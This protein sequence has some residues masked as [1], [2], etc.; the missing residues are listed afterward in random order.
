MIS[1]HGALTVRVI[2][3]RN[4]EFRVGKL[5]SEIGEFTIKSAHIEEFD[6]GLYEGLFSI[7][8]IYASSYTS[9]NRIT[10]EVRAELAGLQLDGVDTTPP[11]AE[12]AEPDPMDEEK[13]AKP[14]P[15][16][17]PA[18]RPATKASAPVE[19]ADAALF[20]ESWPLGDTVK[21]D[22]TVGRDTFRRQRDAL[23]ALGYQF[24]P[25]A[26]TWTRTVQ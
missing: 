16:A 26:Q 11:P 23:K 5:N 6:E 17:K 1:I 4:G 19:A 2:N 9:G 15:K 10:T 12:P 8:K 24:E 3:G 20:G 25:T 18:A 13:A 21:L 14:E 22:P 7:A